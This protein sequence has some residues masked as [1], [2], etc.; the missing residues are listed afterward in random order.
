MK[1]KVALIDESSNKEPTFIEIEMTGEEKLSDFL[2]IAGKAVGVEVISATESTYGAVISEVDEI[3]P[4]DKIH[5]KSAKKRTAD[6]ILVI[7]GARCFTVKGKTNTPL[8]DGDLEV[9]VVSSE[10]GENEQVHMLKI[11]SNFHYALSAGGLPVVVHNRRNVVLPTKE[12]EVFYGITLPQDAKDSLVDALNEVLEANCLLAPSGSKNA[13]GDGNITTDFIDGLKTHAERFMALGDKA[14]QESKVFQNVLKVGKG[15]KTKA[16]S[17]ARDV[18]LEVRKAVTE[19]HGDIQ[20]ARG[21]EEG[22]EKESF[23]KATARVLTSRAKKAAK[24]AGNHAKNLR[25][26]LKDQVSKVIEESRGE[27]GK[28]S[29]SEVAM[30]LGKK[31]YTA[32]KFTAAKASQLTK[33]GVHMVQESMEDLKLKDRL[34]KASEVAKKGIQGLKTSVDGLIKSAKDGSLKGS[35]ALVEKLSSVAQQITLLSKA[36]ELGLWTSEKVASGI[37]LLKKNVA[38]L[39][40]LVKDQ[41]VQL[42]LKSGVAT[43]QSALLETVSAIEAAGEKKEKRGERYGAYLE[44]GTELTVQGIKASTQ[45][46]KMGIQLGKTVIK[47][48]LPA[49]SRSAK[50]HPAIKRAIVMAH[51]YSAGAVVISDAV[52]QEVL[53]NTKEIATRIATTIKTASKTAVRSP[54]SSNTGRLALLAKIEGPIGEA[55]KQA[56]HVM[57]KAAH[58][59]GDIVCA[60][61]DAGVQMVQELGDVTHELAEHRFGSEVGEAVGAG[62]EAYTNVAK[63]MTNVSQV[64]DVK[65]LA[66]KNLTAVV[67]KAVA[68]DTKSGPGDAKSDPG[69]P[70]EAVASIAEGGQNPGGQ[71]ED[72]NNMLTNDA[73]GGGLARAPGG[74]DE[75]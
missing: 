24:Q 40:R 13:K 43:L 60:M 18:N 10:G 56:E 53:G 5:L 48:Q 74:P 36:Q 22:G 31:S 70:S 49:S 59:W 46:I 29:P 8:S 51:Q 72:I 6:R 73:E 67:A 68:G 12:E 35:S 66:K 16:V 57:G 54:N 30:T 25:N 4:G 27:D 64:T 26:E 11:G 63:A 21:G 2:A 1:V 32:V 33:K 45:I 15:M 14:A 38:E 19:L 34:Q 50:L 42:A 23:T 37:V 17:L 44:K 7:P 52:V 65:G 9:L 55:A 28:V 20:Q 61:R 62:V 47:S 75:V 3:M 41:H 39:E 58:A 71:A 69:A